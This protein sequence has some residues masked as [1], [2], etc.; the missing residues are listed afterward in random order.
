M[1]VGIIGPGKVGRA[2]AGYFLDRGIEQVSVWGRNS[3]TTSQLAETLGAH[4]YKH[5]DDLVVECEIIFITVSDKAIASVADVVANG[6]VL[7]NKYIIHCSGALSSKVLAV[8]QDAGAVVASMHPLQAF[9]GGAEDVK[10]LETTYLTLESSIGSIPTIETLV[11]RLGNPYQWIDASAKSLY[12]GAAVVMS[13]Y[14]VTL[15][16]EGLSY[17]RKA[18]FEDITAMSMMLPLMRGALSNIEAK[19]T[20]MGLTGPL[21]RNDQEVINVHLEAIHKQLGE[22]SEQLYRALGLRTI[23]MVRGNRLSETEVCDLTRIFKER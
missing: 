19:G 3:S 15:V 13:N 8:C 2:L 10:H 22:S 6:N 1:K 17:M 20:V 18:G 14:L 4:A 21:V 9:A 5:M 7:T 16:E 11:K 12:H 23:D